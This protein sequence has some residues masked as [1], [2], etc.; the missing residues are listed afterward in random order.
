MPEARIKARV[1]TDASSVGRELGKASTQASQFATRLRGIGKGIG[2]A[3]AAG[4]VVGVAGTAVKK[5]IEDADRIADLAANIGLTTDELQAFEG[6]ALVSG[7]S[8]ENLESGLNKLAAVQADAVA[9]NQAAIDSFSALGIEADKLNG[10][11][12]ELFVA[13]AKGFTETG[14]LAAVQD[15][16][17]RGGVRL[18]Q[19]LREVGKNGGLGELIQAQKDFGNVLSAGELSRLSGVDD[20]LRA[21]MAQAGKIVSATF[22]P[23]AEDQTALE[24]QKRANDAAAQDRR[25][26]AESARAQ[27]RRDQMKDL[28]EIL[29]TATAPEGIGNE[30]VRIGAAGGVRAQDDDRIRIARDS[31]D[32]LKKIEQNTANSGIMPGVF[33]KP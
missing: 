11:L 9:G 30:L 29:G 3:F 19:T 31:L 22:T 16:F 18:T 15:V 6:V 2:T 10:T 32:K 33:T 26:L 12:G 13:A 23:G 20:T 21:R 7:A 14:N 17:G 8:V 5:M 1:D 27:T 24:E 25:R 4:A 28:E